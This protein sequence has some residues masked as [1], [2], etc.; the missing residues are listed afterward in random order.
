[1]AQLQAQRL[2]RLQLLLHLLQHRPKRQ[3]RHRQQT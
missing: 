2:H 3:H 1:V